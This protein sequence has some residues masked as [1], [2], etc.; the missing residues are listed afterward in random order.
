MAG[1]AMAGLAMVA[2]A[3]VG[4]ARQT[5][6]AKTD[7]AG[8]DFLPQPGCHCPR[9]PSPASPAADLANW[10]AEHEVTPALAGQNGS[11]S[12]LRTPPPVLPWWGRNLPGWFESRTVPWNP[13]RTLASLSS[14]VRHP[15]S[16]QQKETSDL[17]P[18]SCRSASPIDLQKQKYH[19]VESHRSRRHGRH[20]LFAEFL[21]Q[22]WPSVDPPARE[23]SDR[24]RPRDYPKPHPDPQPLLRDFAAA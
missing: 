23:P 4:F 13:V 20:L 18:N 8:I 10:R 7:L 16:P 11:S 15:L 14:R 9:K 17:V 6:S 24:F 2:F 21:H 19:S 5:C 1:L 3:M 22:F 12:T